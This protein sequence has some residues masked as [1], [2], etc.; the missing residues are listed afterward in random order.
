MNV[1]SGAGQGVDAFQAVGECAHAEGEAAGGFGGDAAGVEVGGEVSGRGWGLP[2]AV[3]RG[4]RALWTRLAMA[5][6]LL[7]G[8]DHAAGAR[9]GAMRDCPTRRGTVSPS[10]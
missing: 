2:R 10:P 9:L 8:L 5:C 1:A 7:V 3:V 4:P 6:R